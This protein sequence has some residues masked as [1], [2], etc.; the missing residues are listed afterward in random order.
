MKDLRGGIVRSRGMLER[1]AVNTL[2][3]V[4]SE[5]EWWIIQRGIGHLRVG[6]TVDEFADLPD[7][8]AL[9]DAGPSG[10]ERPR[11]YPKRKGKALRNVSA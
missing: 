3:G 5:R 4:G 11:T 1:I 10:P 8:P 6:L 7:F 2:V 9:A